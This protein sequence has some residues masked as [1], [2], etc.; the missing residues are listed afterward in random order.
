MDLSVET[1]MMHPRRGH[2]KIEDT[3]AVM[4][5]EYEMFGSR[6]RGGTG[7]G[8]ECSEKDIS[9]YHFVVMSCLIELALLHRVS[10]PQAPPYPHGFI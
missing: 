4:A 7:V 2:L 5:S 6:G 9:E 10:C 8:F 1:M 3:A